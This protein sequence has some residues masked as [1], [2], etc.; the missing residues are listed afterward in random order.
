MQQKVSVII[1]TYNMGYTLERALESVVAQTYQNVEIIVVDDGST[2]DTFNVVGRFKRSHPDNQVRYIQGQHKNRSSAVNIGIKKASG[3]Y[4]TLL[5]ADDHLPPASLED[6]V[7]YLEEHPDKDLVVTPIAYVD[8]TGH[9][10]SIKAVRL[11]SNPL[12]DAKDFL[13]CLITPFAIMTA[14][15]KQQVFDTAGLLDENLRRADDMEFAIRV[16]KACNVGYFEESTYN[17]TNTTHDL[18]SRLKHRII[19]M[20][21]RL[22]IARKHQD[23]FSPLLLSDAVVLSSSVV[24]LLYEAI[25]SVGFP[26][27]KDLIYIKHS[28]GKDGKL[29]DVYKLATMIPG[30]DQ[31]YADAAY[32][33][34]DQL[35]KI[36]D[37]P[38]ITRVGRFLRRY[39]IDEL[40]QLVNVLRGELGLIGIRPRTEV[41]WRQFS[42]EHKTA[43]LR[44]KPGLLGI[45]YAAR[46]LAAFDDL[47]RLEEGYLREKTQAP[48]ATDLRY[49]AAILVNI[50][51]NGVRST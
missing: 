20:F 4:I 37:D 5:D 46:N 24:K 45:P 41:H 48:V 28:L 13:Y 11:S 33:G 47:V 9:V 49:G 6:R 34:L 10:Y 38:R 7:N 50:L 2:D 51:F 31:Q 25:S 29:I 1:P 35:G 22:K 17:Y 40:P 26:Q 14:M 43:A 21:D 27:I 16:L 19:G 18:A 44:Y 32:A 3:S 8:E 42:P 30:A 15:Y 12:N 36:P 39:W 23:L